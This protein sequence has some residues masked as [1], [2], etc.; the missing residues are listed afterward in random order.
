[1]TCRQVL[2]VRSK[3]RRK[4]LGLILSIFSSTFSQSVGQSHEILGESSDDESLASVK[5]TDADARLSTLLLDESVHLS[6]FLLER[7]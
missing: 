1:M 3:E 4:Y 7:G 5:E 2:R 6:D